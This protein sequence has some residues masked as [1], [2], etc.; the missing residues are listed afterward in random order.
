MMIALAILLLVLA[1]GFTFNNYVNKSFNISNEQSEV[2]F[3][4]RMAK[5]R[6]ENLVRFADNIEILAVWD[7]GLIEESTFEGIYTDETGSLI[8][9]QNGTAT[10]LLAGISDDIDYEITFN[11]KDQV[12][13]LCNIGGETTGGYSYELSTELQILNVEEDTGIIKDFGD[14]STT[15][16]AIVFNFE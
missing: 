4:V 2:Q 6:I 13:L 15:G 9:N 7:T 10:N 8:Y 1:L 5:E 16:T 14:A 11:N 3:N 12:F